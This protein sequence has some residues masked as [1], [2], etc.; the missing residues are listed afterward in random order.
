MFKFIFFKMILSDRDIKEAIKKGHISIEPMLDPE[1]QIQPSSV[2]LRLGNEFRL[3]KYVEMPFIDP[4]NKAETSSMEITEL[5]SI[6]DNERFIVHPGDFLLGTTLEYVKVPD[7]TV[8][9][10]EG[11][12]SMGRLGLIIHST[13]GYIDPGFEGKITLEISNLGKMPVAL[14]AKMRICQIVF[15]KMTSSA[16]RPYGAGRGSKYQKQKHPEESKISQDKEFKNL[17]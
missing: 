5:K 14:Y 6:K 2:D 13:A 7:D 9:R 10:L 1:L 16:E 4:L 17:K 3:F 11:R 8:A 15:E 12:S